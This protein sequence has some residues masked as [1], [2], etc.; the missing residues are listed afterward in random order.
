V[1]L[2]VF[3]LIFCFSLVGCLSTRHG[4]KLSQFTYNEKYHNSLIVDRV[5]DYGFTGKDGCIVEGQLYLSLKS[6]VNSEVFGFVKDVKS[7]EPMIGA[8]VF[9]WFEGQNSPIIVVADANGA[10]DFIRQSTISRIEVVS[11]GYRKMVIDFSRS[12]VL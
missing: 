4:V 11:V 10:F 2:H 1:K 9:I 8:N 3:I 5:P 12:R 7:R 6:S